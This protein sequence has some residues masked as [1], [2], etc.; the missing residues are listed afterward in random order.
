MI[1][2]NTRAC[3]HGLKQVTAQGEVNHYQRHDPLLPSSTHVITG[4]DKA[5]NLFTHDQHYT[6]EQTTETSNR[7]CYKGI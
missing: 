6:C 3:D 7:Q 4:L 5:Y 2:I 1:V